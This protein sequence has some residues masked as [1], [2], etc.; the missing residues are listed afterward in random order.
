[1][2]SPLTLLL[3]VDAFHVDTAVLDAASLA[4]DSVRNAGLNRYFQR[5]GM[6]TR[7]G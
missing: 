2:D 5:K 6:T 3:R 4:V 7:L 1:V